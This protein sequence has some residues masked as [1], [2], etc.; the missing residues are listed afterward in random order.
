VLAG[1][2]SKALY[3]EDEQ[4]K[5][6]QKLT[7]RQGRGLHIPSLVGMQVKVDASIVLDI[8]TFSI[9]GAGWCRKL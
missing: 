6:L 2:F 5:E 7:R 9:L 3:V 1:L 4:C 8:G